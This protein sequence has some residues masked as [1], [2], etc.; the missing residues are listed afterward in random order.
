MQHRVLWFDKYIDLFNSLEHTYSCD[1]SSKIG[2][3]MIYAS[4]K[5]TIKKAFTGLGAEF[6]AND[7][8]DVDY[9]AW[10]ADIEKKA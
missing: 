2:D 7:L 10:A 8:A 3:K 6:Q 1:D 9:D 4:S 5:E